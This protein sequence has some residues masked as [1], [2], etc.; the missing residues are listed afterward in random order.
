M[1]AQQF[2]RRRKTQPGAVRVARYERVE[3]GILQV[4]RYA[5]T[6]VLYFDAGDNPVA[7]IAD[8]EI[9]NRA[10]AQRDRALTIECRRRVTHQVEKGL[11]HLVAVQLDRRQPRIVVADDVQ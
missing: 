1:A 4:R 9:R 8:R 2:L 5:G 3:H 6:V 7:G 11:D 10:A